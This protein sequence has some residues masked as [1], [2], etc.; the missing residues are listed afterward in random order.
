MNRIHSKGSGSMH[1]RISMSRRRKRMSC[2]VKMM[3]CGNLRWFRYL[4][5]MVESEMTS[6]IDVGSVKG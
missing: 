3:E 5:G 6:G 4:E 1:G 2:G